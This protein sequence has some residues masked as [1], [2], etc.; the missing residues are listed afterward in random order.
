MRFHPAALLLIVWGSA[1]VAY[2]ILPFELTFRTMTDEGV[3]I[4]ILFIVAFCFGALLRTVHVPAHQVNPPDKLRFANADFLLVSLASVALLSLGF[5]VFRSGLLD[6]GTAYSQRSNQAQALLHGGLSQSSGL[7]KIGFSC[8]PASFVYLVRCILLERKPRLV[9]LVIFGVLPGIMAGIVMGGRTPMFCT[10]AYGFLAYRARNF[11]YNTRP[12]KGQPTHQFIHPN[13]KIL[14]ILAGSLAFVYFIK[15]FIARAEVLG[16]TEVMFQHV[17]THWGVT[18]SYPSAVLMIEMLGPTVT[19]L[20]FVFSWYL[21]QGIVMSNTLF[22][23]YAG[24]PLI[25]VYGIDI[26]TAVIRRINPEWVAG[27]FNY[28]LDLEVYGFFPSAFGTFFVD[29][30]YIGIIFAAMWGWLAAVVY[31]NIR[32]GSDPR[33]FLFSPFV[34]L[35]I[36]FG[37]V[38]TPLGFSN[39][40]ITHFWLLLAFLL[41][42]RPTKAA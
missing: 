28:L 21:I 33:W 34:T 30:S 16:G 35:G 18:F 11:L 4:L 13:V 14:A 19:Y 8:Y 9:P 10:L 23:E 15:V 31:R 25:G 6:L 17:A 20:I 39:G 26:L 37:L 32:R 29:F 36:V 27:N 1:F 40:F 2:L 22:T 3:L 42:R 38:N 7:F 12:D 5:E 24:E 41:I